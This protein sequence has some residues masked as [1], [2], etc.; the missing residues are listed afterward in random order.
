MAQHKTSLLAACLLGF[1]ACKAV[2][3]G[4]DYDRA[5]K[6]IRTVTGALNVFH[7]AAD[8]SAIE[9]SVIQLLEDGLGF[10]EAVELGLLNNPALQAAFR[11][12]G[13]AHANRVQA[14]LLTN[15]S[16]NAVLRFPTSGGTGEF[17]GGLFGNFLDIWQVADRE[18][19]AEKALQR[20]IYEL[21]H[22]AT[23][24]A[25]DIRIAYVD[26]TTCDKLL[27]IANENGASAKHLFELAEARLE[28]AAGTII[29][30]NLAQLEFLETE[31]AL[32]DAGLA[33]GQARRKL[34]LL[35]GL[36]P[37]D[38]SL[39]LTNQIEETPFP[40]LPL[41][42]LEELALARRLDIRAAQEAVH[43]A[44]AIV[45][46]QRNQFFRNLDVGLATERD[47][48][49]SLGPGIQLELPLFDQNKAQV[50][51]ALEAL[52]QSEAVLLAMQLAAKQEVHSAMAQADTSWEVLAIFRN[53]ILTRSEETLAQARESY[54]LGKSTMLP[55]LEA[56]RR[57][58]AA[59]GAY[60]ERLRQAASALSDLECATGTPREI[61]RTAQVEPRER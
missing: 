53:D 26:S 25:G 30:A 43:Q 48:D 40:L 29:D 16:L 13:I 22:Q 60:A 42:K 55:A 27:E 18:R 49:W 34:V 52:A 10:S 58:L 31:V 8:S 15:P 61:L 19:I 59:R 54:R 37:Q 17:D 9:Q 32:R 41:D 21:T 12:V 7:P 1:T 39:K 45:E 5:V 51:K 6:E 44:R 57:F 33:S 47:G 50:A 28:A 20:Q 36:Q 3:P 38:S 56:Q 2:D 14:G 23:L 46:R 4:P 11:N 35:L 24:L